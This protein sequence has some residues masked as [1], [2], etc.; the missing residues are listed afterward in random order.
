MGNAHLT[1][2]SSGL[3]IYFIMYIF[4]TDHIS[5]IRKEGKFSSLAAVNIREQN[6]TQNIDFVGFRSSTQPT[7]IAYSSSI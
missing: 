5:F 4:D 3:I 1:L 7:K 6:Q 2:I